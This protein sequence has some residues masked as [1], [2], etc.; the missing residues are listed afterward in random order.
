[1]IFRS[2]IIFAQHCSSMKWSITGKCDLGAIDS[3]P[4]EPHKV[5]GL[6]LAW[7]ELGEH[8]KWVLEAAASESLRGLVRNGLLEIAF[9]GAR[10]LYSNTRLG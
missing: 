2:G 7:R 1:M 10:K 6:A 3:D 4:Q 5:Y 8:F 9:R